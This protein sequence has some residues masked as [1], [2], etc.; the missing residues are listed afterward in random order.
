M[1][2]PTGSQADT[3]MCEAS[4]N[5]SSSS[6][7]STSSDSFSEL[8]EL[9]NR[10]TAL[11]ERD[12]GKRGLAQWAG[13]GQVLPAALSLIDAHTVAVT[14]GFFVLHRS[15]EP[16]A[17]LG[18]AAAG[19]ATQ[20]ETVQEVAARDA[21][22]P[23]AIE[24]DG[25]PG[26]IVLARA[27][28]ALGKDVALVV[29]DH[30]AQIMTAGIKASG[31]L[32]A[33]VGQAAGSMRLVA[34]PAGD[35][36]ELRLLAREPFSHVVAVERPG[37]SSSGAC[38]SM[39]EEDI[40][41]YVAATDELFLA[42]ERRYTTIGIGDGGNE[43]GLHAVSE[44]L[45]RHLH[46]GSRISCRT[47]AD[48]CIYAGV[49][50]WGAYGLCALL[51]AVA[52]RPLLPQPEEIV[53]LLTALVEAGAVDGI[54]RKRTAT[55]DG[56]PLRHESDVVSELR[57]LTDSFLNAGARSGEHDTGSGNRDT[58]SDAGSRDE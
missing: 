16:A 51:S 25:P 44:K 36:A 35:S 14:T 8:R 41:R 18:E 40:S 33:A 45:G 54:S 22:V 13:V 12:P 53:S 48:L 50:N 17:E 49:S 21:A 38:F 56:L 2:T 24:T 9:A 57:E 32:A 34:L 10:V 39:R 43:L 4:N 58:E 20:K 15:A 31:G 23:G 5:S 27:L 11:I 37:R 46:N 7:S 26:A 52:R 19:H 47:P 3:R 55:V 1:T 42:P 28:T 29:D 30:A 6:Q